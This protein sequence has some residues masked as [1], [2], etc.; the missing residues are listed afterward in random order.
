MVA[1]ML[2]QAQQFLNAILAAFFMWLA[3]LFLVVFVWWGIGRLAWSQGR[4]VRAIEGLE[5]NTRYIRTLQLQVED[6]T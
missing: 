5:R 3:L 1:S 6:L 2:L 4:V